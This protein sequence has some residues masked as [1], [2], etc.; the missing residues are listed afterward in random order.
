MVFIKNILIDKK[1]EIIVQ[2][3]MKMAKKMNIKTICEGIETKEQYLKLKELVAE[4]FV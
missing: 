4:L 3:I 1:A 2:Q